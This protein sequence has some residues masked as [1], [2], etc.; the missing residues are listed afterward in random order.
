MQKIYIYFASLYIYYLKSFTHLHC[1]HCS[2][3]RQ[4]ARRA[5]AFACVEFINDT[6]SDERRFAH[7]HPIFFFSLE[8]VPF[9]WQVRKKLTAIRLAGGDKWLSVLAESWA[10]VKVDTFADGEVNTQRALVPR[11]ACQVSQP[12]GAGTPTGRSGEVTLKCLCFISSQL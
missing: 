1:V 9:C 5:A 12:G 10:P 8:K 4:N 6:L 7:P 11:A 3:R 2:E